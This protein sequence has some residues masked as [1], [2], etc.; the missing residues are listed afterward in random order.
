ML[1]EVLWPLQN[2]SGGLVSTPEFFWKNYGP[3][4]MLL[5]ELLCELIL[6]R[7]HPTAFHWNIK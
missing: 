1:L 2:S 4:R 7:F 5:E 3:S 6:W